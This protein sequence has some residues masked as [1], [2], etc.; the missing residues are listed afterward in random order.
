ME[1]DLHC[2]LFRGNINNLIIH[3]LKVLNELFS[4]VGLVNLILNVDQAQTIDL[5]LRYWIINE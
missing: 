3:K 4:E 2:Q 5:Q 1:Y